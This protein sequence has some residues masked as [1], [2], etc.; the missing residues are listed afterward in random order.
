VATLQFTE[1]PKVFTTNYSSV[2]CNEEDFAKQRRHFQKSRTGKVLFVGSLAQRYK[3]ADIL[4]QAVARFKFDILLEVIIAG[5]G[6][7]RSEL[8]SLA[9]KLGIAGQV[10]FLGELPSGRAVQ[11]Q[12]DR[13]TLF[14]MPSRTEGLPRAMIEAMAR[15]LPCLGTRVGGIPELLDDRDLVAAD[16]ADAL[17]EKMNEV[18]SSPERLMEMS[19]RN[20]E[21]AQEYRPELLER[22][23]N[24]FYRSL[25]LITEQSLTRVSVVQHRESELCTWA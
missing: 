17:A 10:K 5:D 13:A 12:M 20:L 9:A 23:R 15:A 7:H 24:E 14:V 8:E 2:A 4:L 22:R 1:S 3:G 11:E 25:R 16:N 19:A 18:L 21:R 6:K